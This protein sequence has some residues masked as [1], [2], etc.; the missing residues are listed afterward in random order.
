MFRQMLFLVVAFCNVQMLP[1]I[2]AAQ[3]SGSVSAADFNAKVGPI[4]EAIDDLYGK[5]KDPDLNM[6]QAANLIEK[7]SEL[8]GQINQL[9]SQTDEGIADSIRQLKQQRADYEQ[10]N[11]RVGMESALVGSQMDLVNNV[12]KYSTKAEF[13][14]NKD[15]MSS[16]WENAYG[17][18]LKPFGD[19]FAAAKDDLYRR[20]KERYGVEPSARIGVS[21]PYTGEA[22]YKYY[23]DKG[24]LLGGQWVNDA[25]GW[26]KWSNDV[27]ASW[28]RLRDQKDAYDTSVNNIK[29]FKNLYASTKSNV[30]RNFGTV[31]SQSKR[32]NFVGTWTGNDNVGNWLRMTL[33]SDGTTRYTWGKSSTSYDG[34][35]TWNQVGSRITMRT[36]DGQ[37]SH[38]STITEQFKLEF[39]ETSAD[40]HTYT[41]FLSR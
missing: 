31:E 17:S 2:A 39:I 21:N 35:G 26:Q 29:D 38:R 8:R 9:W 14:Q 19:D 25:A 20:I 13:E 7:Q 41:N 18:R 34:A 11:R 1:T 37:W 6:N 23:D 3:N 32:V 5:L 22:Y 33:R 15:Q 12:G 28:R 27:N 40:G 4:N 30:D 16:N 36:D 10:T 24:D